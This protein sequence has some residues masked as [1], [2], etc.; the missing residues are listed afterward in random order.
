MP[1]S[2]VYREITTDLLNW[3]QRHAR[4]LPW[5][6]EAQQNK[7]DPYRVW[8]S[9]IMLQQTT[10]AHA[11]PYYQK[12]VEKW[13]SVDDLAAADEADVMAEWAGL[14]YYSRARNLIR[15][16][17]EVVSSGSV[18]PDSEEGLLALP[19][20]GRYTAAAITAIAFGKRAV[21][22]DAN[23]ERVVSR[24]FAIETP[25]PA[26]RPIIAEETD[27]LTPDLAAGDFAQAMMDIGA[28]ICVNRQPVC[29]ICPMMSHCEGQKTGDPARFPIKAPKKI[30]PKRVGYAFILKAKDKILLVRRP[31]KGLLGGMRALPS[32]EWIDQTKISER[33]ESL[34]PES[35][36]IKE[37]FCHFSPEDQKRLEDFSW[38][39]QGYIEHIFTHFA[40]QLNIFYAEIET[41]SVSGEWWPIA[42]IKSAGLPTV[43]AKGVK[44]HIQQ[45]GKD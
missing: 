8:L 45:T 20:I 10:T 25:L 31:D 39:S 9:E 36:A 37:A 5:R 27:K 44:K 23:V 34:S 3:Y 22:V 17:K 38:Q 43:F 6:T 13:P 7:V 4:I 35:Q 1:K 28:T 16:A 15:C 24:L 19:G 14:G 32:G 30:R 11:A 40:L 2:A 33:K 18:F 42:E 41:E 26:S 21:V 12:F 29:A